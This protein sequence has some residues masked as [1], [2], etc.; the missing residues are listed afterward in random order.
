MIAT[1]DYSLI[2]TKQHSEAE[3]DLG[4]LVE[5]YGPLLFRVAYSI[6]R[7]RAEAED[8]VQD[9]LVRVIEHRKALPGVRDLRVWLVRIC[10]N[11]ALDRRRRTRPEQ[12]D[13]IFAA[14]LV[15]N[16]VPADRALDET[17][18]LARLMQAIDRL[19]KLEKQA[20]LLS[21]VD[22]LSMAE[23]AAVLGR[24]ESAVRA[25]VFRARTKLKERMKGGWR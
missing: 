17:R 22:E 23:A 5:S 4:G 8:I 3:V 15:G 20:L 19:P 24:T 11:L 10:W 18:R 14:S 2:L 13:E 9:T 16:E 12:I 6:V 25:L 1:G 7:S 21:A